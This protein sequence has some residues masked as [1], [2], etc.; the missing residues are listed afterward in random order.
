MGGKSSSP[1]L[2]APSPLPS[3]PSYQQAFQDYVKSIP[4][5][6]AAEQKY[7]PGFAQ[8]QLDLIQQFGIP[9][10]QALLGIDQALYPQTSQLQEA[11]A[12]QALQGLSSQLPDQ[13]AQQYM[14][15][16]NAGI[17]IN[18]NAPIGVSSR[19]IGLYNLQ[20][21]WRRYYRDLAL[22]TSGRQPLRSGTAPQ[23]GTPTQG[24][25][26]ALN[27]Q[28]QTYGAYVPALA[29]QNMLAF[30]RGGRFSGSGAATGL[31]GGAASGAVIG[32][33]VPGIGTAVGAG[34]GGLIG[35]LG[36]GFA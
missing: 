28:A 25:P 1:Q 6:L 14:S 30:P 17:G 33:L 29:Q 32:S 12:S 10:S 26:G 3:P 27:Y 36:G 15:D 20:E 22:T 5:F 16:F 23:M 24:L 7:G 34:V 35:G 2:I 31:L 21:D 4:D 19:N 9:T 18:A 13:L 11:V 8:S